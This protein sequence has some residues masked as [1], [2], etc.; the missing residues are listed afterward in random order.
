M[1]LKR[2]NILELHPIKNDIRDFFGQGKSKV[3]NKVMT[4]EEM[5]VAIMNSISE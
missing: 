5:D 1:E 2:N 4:I 3:K